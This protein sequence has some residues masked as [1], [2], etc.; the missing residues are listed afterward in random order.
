MSNHS[1]TARG[2]DL[3]FSHRSMVSITLEQNIICSKTLI[4]RQL[5][6]GHVVGSWPMK[7]KEKIHRMIR[8]S[9]F[10]DGILPFQKLETMFWPQKG[11]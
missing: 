8:P 10:S 9:L 11:G 1:L 4:C 5:F 3:P 2:T 6:A 7:K